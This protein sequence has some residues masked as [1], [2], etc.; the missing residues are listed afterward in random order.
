[1]YEVVMSK[2]PFAPITAIQCKI[3]HIC[4]S[5]YS[6]DCILGILLKSKCEFYDCIFLQS[7]FKLECRKM[8]LYTTVQ[9]LQ[10]A[11]SFCNQFSNQSAER[12]SCIQLF[13]YC[14]QMQ[15]KH[16]SEYFIT[17][18]KRSMLWNDWEHHTI[19]NQS[20]NWVFGGY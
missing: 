12:C 18:S 10:I 6:F 11:A 19:P 3:Q 4:I 1:M 14:R 17:G 20:Q 7:L 16:Q 13:N 15:L 8:Q 9:L 2:A 5:L